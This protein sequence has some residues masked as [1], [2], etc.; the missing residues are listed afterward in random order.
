MNGLARLALL[1]SI[2]TFGCM[3]YALETSP[4]GVNPD[5]TVRDK[6]AQVCVV[7]SAAMG[8]PPPK[9]QASAGP[10]TVSMVRDDG[11]LV[12]SI[13]GSGFFCY[14][15]L[16]GTHHV[17]AE[18]APQ[19][20]AVDVTLVAGRRIFLRQSSAADGIVID[21]MPEPEARAAIA[22]LRFASLTAPPGEAP[23]VFV[24]GPEGRARVLPPPPQQRPDGIAYGAIA[25]LGG[26]LSRNATAAQPSAAFAALGSIWVGFA[27]LDL[28]L[29][30]LRI[31]AGVVGDGLGDVALHLACFPGA[32][33]SGAER[34]FKLFV[35]AGIGGPLSI[36]NGLS[37]GQNG[38]AGIG[39]VGVAWERWR[40]RGAPIGPFL[41]VQTAHGGG[42]D[43]T[44]ALAGFGVS[45]F[46]SRP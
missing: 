22:D 16:P 23:A 36:T 27:S 5:L 42:L 10:R 9:P 38:V 15:V 32:R 3:P 33:G 25:G 19:V 2:S 43:Q 12:G 17:T 30:G 13:Q 20:A 1:A 4:T 8:A 28:F 6:V 44:A 31:D 14:E 26:G 24:A 29:V 7:R 37:F 21:L 46:A 11:K 39:R 34:D 18:T 40:V 45:I 35:E 41:A